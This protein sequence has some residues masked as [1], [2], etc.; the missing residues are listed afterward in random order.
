[1]KITN[2]SAPHF[3]LLFLSCFLLLAALLPTPQAQA[4]DDKYVVNLISMKREIRLSAVKD[5]EAL[6]RH[7]D[8]VVYTKPSA[9][10][11]YHVLSVGYFSSYARA[12]QV[13]DE[14]ASVYQGAYPEK[15]VSSYTVTKVL[16]LNSAVPVPTVAAAT[17]PLINT[18]A[19]SDGRLGQLM[20]S[21]RSAIRQGEN[22]KAV[23][24]LS[25]ILSVDENSHS[26]E[27]LE[28][29]GVARERNG[30]QNHAVNAYNSYIEKYPDD[31]DTR[32]VKQRLAVLVTADKRVVAEVKKDPE[33]K[34]R[35]WN[36]SGSLAQSYF[37]NNGDDADLYTFLNLAGRKRNQDTD[38]RLQ[39]TGSRSSTLTGDDE[40][41][42]RISEMYAD[43]LFTNAHFATKIGRQ[44]SRTGGFFGR[45][46]GLMLSYDTGSSK[47]NFLAG[48]P[49]DNSAEYLFDTDRN[50]KIAYGVNADLTFF[51]KLLNLNLYALEQR[52][53]D[54][55]DRQVVGAEARFYTPS[56][57]MFGLLDYDV[58]YDEVNVF[59]LTGNWKFAED[60][61][62]Y[63]NMDYRNSS[64]LTTSNALSGQTETDLGTLVS[65]LGE[66][67]VRQ[68]A[69]DRTSSSKLLSLGLLAPLNE[70]TTVR[71]DI[72]ISEISALPAS[73]TLPAMPEI[74]PD[75]YYSLQF[76]SRNFFVQNDTTITQFQ[77]R[78][79]ETSS[80]LTALLTT[81]MPI[82]KKLRIAPR[83]VVSFSDLDIGDDRKELKVS[84]RTDYK[85]S[86]SLQMDL[87]LGMNFTDVDNPEIDT[88]NDYY[89][90]GSYHWLF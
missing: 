59:L 39:F 2:N 24:L 73:G 8:V 33:D 88:Q 52:N 14:L 5:I 16:T 77:Y 68:L 21:A 3:P 11:K 72:S 30:Q 12:R 22:R 90:I 42:F 70:S 82:T 10:G 55:L 17:K 15:F 40:A 65:V 18:S 9:S 57:A 50:K 87:D 63:I 20:S 31:E 67:A 6:K 4:A 56:V 44:R 49:V 85:Y 23:Q 74:G 62:L 13:A 45:F 89:L 79:A 84:L 75:Y 25:A 1:M 26:R 51:D 35:P 60:Y 71:G 36:M 58:S 64:F 43:L 29:L 78:D 7:Y 83:V 81:R 34:S 53:D 69:L 47:Y 66:E 61:D 80:R 46:D 86:R 28:L 76:V 32:R 37:N 27:A 38:L 54:I 48:L 19:L 41:E